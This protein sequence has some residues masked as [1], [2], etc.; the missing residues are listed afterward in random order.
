MRIKNR[1]IIT[2]NET[3][4]ILYVYI[5]SLNKYRSPF[6]FLYHLTFSSEIIVLQI[7]KVRIF[8]VLLDLQLPMSLIC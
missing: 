8:F 3:I 6:V 5:I 1:L 7:C 2:D 4:G